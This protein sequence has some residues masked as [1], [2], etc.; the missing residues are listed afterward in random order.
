MIVN[1]LALLLVA[2]LASTAAANAQGG[3]EFYSQK[4]IRLIVGFPPGGDY[5]VGGR[6]LAKYL[7]RHIPGRP[8]VIVQNMPGA[9]SVAAATFIFNRAPHDGTVLGSFSRNVPTQTILGQSGIQFDLRR[10]IW[11]GGT[12]QPSVRVCAKWHS[13]SRSVCGRFVP[14]RTDRS[15]WWSQFRSQHHSHG[16]QQCDRNQIPPRRGVPRHVSCD[17]GDGAGRGRGRVS[18]PVAVSDGRQPRAKR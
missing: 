1:R 13:R 4:Q 2:S 14:A 9:S 3:S 11:I 6:L 16:P 18:V 5:D 15:R 17:D 12:S 7:G 8:T 10:F